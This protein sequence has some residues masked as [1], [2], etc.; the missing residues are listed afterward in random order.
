MQ[1]NV[2][3]GF[4]SRQEE[5]LEI[6]KNQLAYNCVYNQLS[7]ASTKTLGDKMSAVIFDPKLFALPT[8]QTILGTHYHGK[9]TFMA[10]AW[11]TRV[12]YQPP[13]IA[14]SVN[15]NHASHEA[16][17]LEKQFSLAVPSCEMVAVTDYVGLVSAKKT[18][19]S[20]LFDLFYGKL[21]NAPLI[22]DCPLNIALSL[23]STVEL[24]TNSVFLGE[25]VEAWCQDSLLVD[26]KPDMKKVNPFILTMPQ[27]H[28]WSLGEKVGDAWKAG[29]ELMGR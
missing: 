4:G 24:P 16:I 2:I 26:G 14:I 8:T 11:A 18:D 21:E 27:N 3:P 5:Q 29:R 1:L 15:H 23:H 28:Y 12:N 9:P 7:K 10:L 20:R 22:R 17:I 25:I 6:K 19:K 13:L